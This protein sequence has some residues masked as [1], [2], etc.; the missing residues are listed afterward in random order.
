[1]SEITIHFVRHGEV[2]NP[3]AVFYARLPRFR[4][5]ERGHAEAAAAAQY[6]AARPLVAVYHSPMLRARQ[7][8]SHISKAHPGATM[9]QSR[10]LN[11]VHTP[12]QGYTH[13][14][15]EAMHWDMYSNIAP[16]YE[17]PPDILRRIQ[18]FCDRAARTY[19]GTEVAA[20]THG[21][22]VVFAQLWARGLPPTQE[23]RMS[24]RPYPATASVTT[25]HL[26]ARGGPE[27]WSFA[28]TW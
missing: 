19:P 16:E 13:A 12:F 4:L 8:A 15:M 23:H 26:N 14:Q 1:M 5:S 3:G 9:H 11:E 28:Q 7:T 6:L 20:V 17:R 25:L 22:V 21:D 27:R 2:H 10:F 24:I 18:S